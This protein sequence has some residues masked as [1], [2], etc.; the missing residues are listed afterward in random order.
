MRFIINE[1]FFDFEGE[2]IVQALTKRLIKIAGLNLRKITEMINENANTETTQQN[3]SNKLSKGTLRLSE[4]I[5]ICNFCGYRIIFKSIEQPSNEAYYEV[6][7]P[8]KQDYIKI[9]LQA[10]A[11]EGFQKCTFLFLGDTII[12]GNRALEAVKQTLPI[13]NE[14]KSLAEDLHILFEMVRQYEIDYLVRDDRKTDK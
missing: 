1:I 4:F 12:L 11:A 13:I 14:S 3:L 6:Q 10:K 8:V 5:D 9:D 2:N 7:K